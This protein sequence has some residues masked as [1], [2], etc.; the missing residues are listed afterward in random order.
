MRTSDLL[1]LKALGKLVQRAQLLAEVRIPD[2]Q[3]E[4]VARQVRFQTTCTLYL[5][6]HTS[7]QQL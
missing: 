1:L 3:D 4:M 2:M 5:H 6:T 7:R